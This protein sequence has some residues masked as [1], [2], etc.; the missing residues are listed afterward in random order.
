MIEHHGWRPYH[1]IMI[2][3][4]IMI[5]I[6][7]IWNYNSL[8]AATRMHHKAFDYSSCVAITTELPLDMSKPHFEAVRTP[9]GRWCVR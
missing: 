1:Y 4:L 7:C 9:E 6:V 3:I 5:N 8:L 2:A